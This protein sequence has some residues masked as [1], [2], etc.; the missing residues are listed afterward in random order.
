MKRRGLSLDVVAYA[1]PQE[2]TRGQRRREERSTARAGSPGDLD[3]EPG[4]VVVPYR[5]NRN[6]ES[7]WVNTPASM[8][9]SK[10]GGGDEAKRSGF[11][12]CRMNSSRTQ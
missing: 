1:A 12:D 7:I 9:L 5:T 6:V 10:A 11:T 8:T 3:C 4:E 2:H